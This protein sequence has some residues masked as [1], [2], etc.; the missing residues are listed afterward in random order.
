V[1][2]TDTPVPTPTI[3]L[4]AAIKTQKILVFEDMA[5]H[6]WIKPAL[7]KADYTYT[8]TVDRIGTFKKELL[9]GKWDLIIA[10][11][12]GRGGVGGEFWE[13]IGKQLDDGASVILEVWTL[14]SG[15][16]GGMDDILEK[17]GIEVQDDWV[18]PVDGKVYWVDPESAMASEPNL[19]DLE[20]YTRFWKGDVGDLV[21]KLP[22]STAEI[23]ASANAG[24]AE[25]DG[26]ITVCYDGRLILQ[27]F[28][29]HDHRRDDMAKLWQ[30]Y[31][32]YALKNR[33][34]GGEK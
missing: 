10:A 14:D 32:Y 2:P 5:F 23:V 4:A 15:A 11:A 9:A 19:L 6:R 16:G 21:K 3:D 17:C 18:N 12:E 34:E 13:Y 31:V 28:S 27:T 8:D 1:P 20:H 26:L 30:N 33:I 24:N 22:G 25:M 29:T 7:D